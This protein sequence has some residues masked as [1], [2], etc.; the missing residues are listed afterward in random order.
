MK[1]LKNTLTA[2]Q[3]SAQAIASEIDKAVHYRYLSGEGQA[4]ADKRATS[5]PTY[6][7]FYVLEGDA[8][9]FEVKRVY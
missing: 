9:P 5:Q 2:L 3:I 6:A 7:K 1:A 4:G 8:L